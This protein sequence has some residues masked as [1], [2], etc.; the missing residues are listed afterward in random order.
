MA[1]APMLP[2]RGVDEVHRAADALGAA[3][4]SPHQLGE[5]GLGRHAQGERLAVTA[6]GVG[7]D[8]AL[9]HG[10]DGADRDGLLALAE[11]GGAL[12]QAGHE[13]L[14]DLL[15]EQPDVPH[16]AV[17]ADPPVSA[18]RGI[19]HRAS[20][21]PRVWWSRAQEPMSAASGGGDESVSVPRRYRFQ[22][23]RPWWHRRSGCVNRCVLL[24]GGL[25]WSGL[26][27]RIGAV[28][29]IGALRAH[30]GCAPRD[31]CDD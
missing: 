31:H 5:R 13:Q 21:P 16:L 3:R 14:L 24:A 7:L 11:V 15:L 22:C 4:G 10:R 25:R 8:V 2:V 26:C 17:P 23:L 30:R 18:G 28:P 27:A 9:A 12:D 6:V 29:R 1:L 19:G 20:T